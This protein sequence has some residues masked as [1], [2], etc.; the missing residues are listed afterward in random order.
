MFDGHE[1]NLRVQF[2]RKRIKVNSINN[3]KS[4]ILNLGSLVEYTGY[5]QVRETS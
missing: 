4:Q 1:T 5:D 2:G 3:A